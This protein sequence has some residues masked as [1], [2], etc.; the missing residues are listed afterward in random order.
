[1]KHIKNFESFINE[2]EGKVQK[3]EQ[4]AMNQNTAEG[5]LKA[6]VKQYEDKYQTSYTVD[7]GG[8]KLQFSTMSALA[9]LTGTEEGDSDYGVNVRGDGTIEMFYGPDDQV[10]GKL[11]QE[12]LSAAMQGY[13]MAHKK[14]AELWKKGGKKSADYY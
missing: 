12:K 10:G 14:A 3:V 1:M 5:L 4:G 6:A 8:K 2:N 13:V 11:N 9:A 7:M